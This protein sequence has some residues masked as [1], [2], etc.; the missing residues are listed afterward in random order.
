MVRI[1]A[2]G[3]RYLFYRGYTHQLSRWKG[4]TKNAAVGAT[5]LIALAMF[6]NVMTVFALVAAVTRIR[7]PQEISILGF[8]HVP[9]AYLGAIIAL[10]SAR[11]LYIFYTK[12]GVEEIVKR[13]SGE[14]PEDRKRHT[15][16]IYFYT[17]ITILSFAASLVVATL[18][19]RAS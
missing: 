18:L 12:Q 3:L 14:D 10:A 9:L 15:L 5:G 1:I 2:D 11:Y 17:I 7:V 6:A 13:Y 8:S 4:D 19:A 16:Y